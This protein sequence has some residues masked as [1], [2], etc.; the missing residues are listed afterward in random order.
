MKYGASLVDSFPYEVMFERMDMMERLYIIVSWGHYEIRVLRF[1]LKSF[2]PGRVVD[3][4]NHAEFEFHFIP[5]GKGKVILADT[6]FPLSEGMFYLTGPGVMHYQEASSNKAMDELCL[7][8][9]IVHKCRDNV[10]PWEAAE[11][12]ECIEKLRYFPLKP[13]QDTHNAMNCFL[14]AYE[15]ADKKYKGY[16]TSI[17]QYVISILLKAVRAWDSG[18]AGAEAPIRDMLEHRYQYAIQYIEANYTASLTLESVAEK[19]NISPRQLQRVFRSKD[20]HKPFSKIV[21]D[22]RLTAVCRRLEESNL[23]IE[24]VAQSEGFSNATY[25]HSVFRRRFGM[26]PADYRKWKQL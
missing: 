15:A 22:I 20:E 24:Q 6:L 7:H 13:V 2:E 14:E 12:E 18:D 10:D 4:H 1:H 23:P 3:F 26:T 21:E 9:D 25:L 11:A 19:L 5:R 17:K 8:L 16:Y